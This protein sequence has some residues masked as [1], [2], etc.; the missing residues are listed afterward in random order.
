MG[1]RFIEN[2]PS[3]HRARL[4][5]TYHRLILSNARSLVRLVAIT[6]GLSRRGDAAPV[7]SLDPVERRT[8]QHTL[9]VLEE[10]SGVNNIAKVVVFDSTHITEILEEHMVTYV[11]TV[12][13][14][15]IEK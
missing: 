13:M 12:G 10:G 2:R 9:I 11:S 14:F 6:R 7:R 4:H 5:C 8:L 15:G 1:I 3:R